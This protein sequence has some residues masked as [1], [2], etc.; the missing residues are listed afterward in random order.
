MVEQDAGRAVGRFDGEVGEL[1]VLA[2]GDG[3]DRA[4]A[5][6]GDDGSG[7]DTPVGVARWRSGEGVEDGLG[8]AAAKGDFLDA[9]E[10][11]VLVILAGEDADFSS[12][13]GKVVDGLLD[14]AVDAEA[15][16]VVA[17]GDGAA[18]AISLSVAAASGSAAVG[19]VGDG[20]G[21]VEGDDRELGVV[22][23]DAARRSGDRD[24]DRSSGL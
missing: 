22:V 17:D 10:S 21:G 2:V 11:D 12:G 15:G 20:A 1:N 8:T 3:D 24:V 4:D 7:G 13:E 16:L 14:G 23:V 19:G 18:A 6:V 9:G 5:A